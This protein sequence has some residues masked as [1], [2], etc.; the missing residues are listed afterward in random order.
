MK[1]EGNWCIYKGEMC[2]PFGIG[3][4]VKEE[5]KTSAN[6][7]YTEGQM[8]PPELW[9]K[10]FLERFRSITAA[11][12]KFAELTKVPLYKIKES[13]AENFPSRKKEILKIN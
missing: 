9:D 1:E 3:K 6:V 10:K 13:T 5:S 12:K 11:I 7:A 2:F 4:I 8:Y